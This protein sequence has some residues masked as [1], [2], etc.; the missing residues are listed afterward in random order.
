[1]DDLLL[2]GPEQP[3]DDAVGLGLGDEGV[4]RRP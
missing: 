4:A 2:E 1:M 3:L